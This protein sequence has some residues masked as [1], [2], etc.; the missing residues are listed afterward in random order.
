MAEKL[1]MQLIHPDSF[2][3]LLGGPKYRRAFLDWGVFHV[4]PQFHQIWSQFKK[5]AKQR[6]ALLKTASNYQQMQAWDRLLVPLVEQIHHWRQDYVESLLPKAQALCSDFLPDFEINFDYRRGWESQ[7]AYADVLVANFERDRMIGY[8]QSGAHKADLV[9]R[10]GNIPVADLLSRGQLKL[11]VCAL[12]LAQGQVLASEHQ[13][14]CIYLIDDFASELD[15]KRRSLL[16]EQLKLI[17]S[18]VFVSAISADQ[19]AEMRHETSKMF[20][21]EHGK[22]TAQ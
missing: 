1:P 4:E 11:L 12:R 6:N 20:H 19:I 14:S 5:I 10:V 7:S 9:V 17:Q 2:E 8:T 16:I 3:L 21:V 15:E 13:K 22:I 18:Q